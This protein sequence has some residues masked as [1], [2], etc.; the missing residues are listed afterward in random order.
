MPIE[1]EI[2]E[3][4]NGSNKDWHCEVIEVGVLLRRGWRFELEKERSEETGETGGGFEEMGGTGD[5]FEIGRTDGLG[6]FN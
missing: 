2:A 3:P 6:A 5:G 4:I 1:Y